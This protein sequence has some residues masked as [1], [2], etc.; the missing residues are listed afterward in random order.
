MFLTSGRIETNA[1]LFRKVT[2]NIWHQ[3]KVTLSPKRVKVHMNRYILLRKIIGTI[4]MFLA[5]IVFHLATKTVG[6]LVDLR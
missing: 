5:I 4:S 1:S 2:V 6:T 3:A